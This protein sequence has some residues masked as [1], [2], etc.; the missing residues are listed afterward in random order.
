M[1][2]LCKAKLN[3]IYQ[4]GQGHISNIHFWPGR[5]P[6]T[7]SRAALIATLLP[8]PGNAE[9]RKQILERLG[10]RLVTRV[11]SKKLPDGRIEEQ[12]SEET[13]GGILHWG[14]ESSADLDWFREKI[15]AAYGG[16]APKVL[17]PFAGGGAIRFE[18]MRLGCDVTAVDINPV[19]WFLLKCTLEYPQK[20]VGQKRPLPSFAIADPNFMEAFLTSQKLKGAA[21]RTQLTKLF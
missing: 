15:R 17:D 10:G 3:F 13:E 4:V 5:R 6:W 20:L 18:A 1:G 8:D 14:P 7:A 9:E 19:A 11:K 21:L 12:A 2:I 16:H